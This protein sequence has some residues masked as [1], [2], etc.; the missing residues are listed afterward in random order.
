[1]AIYC[2]Q[3]GTEASDQIK[4]CKRCG[5]SLQLVQTLVT[6][7]PGALK[8]GT[9]PRDWM[10]AAYEDYREKRKKSPEQKR[11]EEMKAGVISMSAGVGA[12]IFLYFLLHAVAAAEPGP[13]AQILNNVWL[14]GLVPFLV[15]LAMIF[16]A[17]FISKK[18]VAL[19]QEQ[20]RERGATWPRQSLDAAPPAA[21]LF[22]SS[23]EPV[24]DFSVTEPTTTRLKEPLPAERGRDTAR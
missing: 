20:E 5:T 10:R 23:E 2:P 19:K 4:F 22:E 17:I 12:M 11:L 14:A 1:M 21:R 7:G 9:D 6:R 15:G 3:C 13:D 24:A 8:E 18:I 16:N